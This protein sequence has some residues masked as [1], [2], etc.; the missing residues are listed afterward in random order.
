MERIGRQPVFAQVFLSGFSLQRPKQELLLP[1][2]FQNELNG[3]IAQVTY[4]IEQN[5]VFRTPTAHYNKI[6][7]RLGN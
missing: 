5:N 1:V 4:P 6:T 2:S 3:T 7:A